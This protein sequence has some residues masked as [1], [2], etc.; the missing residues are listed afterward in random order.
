ME[1]R[2]GGSRTPKREKGKLL[3]RTLQKSVNG[4]GHPGVEEKSECMYDD[5]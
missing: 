4:M 5:C 1:G 2:K 3:N